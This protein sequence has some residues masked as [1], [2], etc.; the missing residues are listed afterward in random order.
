MHLQL[1]HHRDVKDGQCW[2]N[3][4]GQDVVM[5]GLGA[6]SMCQE[7]AL[8]SPLAHERLPGLFIPVW[9]VWVF[10][11]RVLEE[12]DCLEGSY[13]TWKSLWGDQQVQRSLVHPTLDW[14]LR[15][16]TSG[17]NPWQ[18]MVIGGLQL[19]GCL[20]SESDPGGTPGLTCARARVCEP[21]RPGGEVIYSAPCLLPWRS[22]WTTAVTVVTHR[23]FYKMLPKGQA[24]IDKMVLKS[25]TNRGKIIWRLFSLY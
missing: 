10:Y 25:K 5:D 9:P 17:N 11:C 12:V 4:C 2:A 8:P 13:K 16:V 20:K 19:L 1:R 6:C 21:Q 3:E 23:E 14:S 24:R 22:V 7:L 15:S 18:L